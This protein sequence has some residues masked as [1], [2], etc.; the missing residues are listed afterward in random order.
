MN[1]KTNRLERLFFAHP[2]S[3]Q[4]YKDHPEVVLLDC[5]YKTNRFRMPLLNICAVTGNRKTVQVALCFLSGEKEADYDWAMSHFQDM[6]EEHGILEPDTWV[7]DRELALMNTL[8]DLFPDIDHILCTWHVNMNILANCRKHYP[9]DKQ[10]LAKKTAVNPQGYIPDPQWVK[11]LKDWQALLDSLTHAEYR[12]RLSQFCTH[13]KAAVDYIERVWLVWKE[14]L[15]R[16]WVDRCLHFG[17]RVTSPIEGCHAV[18]KAYLRVSTGDLKGVFDRL[19]LYW[20]TQHRDILDSRAQEQN[21]VVHHLNRRY[22][23]L[24]QGLVHDKALHLIIKEKAKLHKAE[25]EAT[26]LTEPCQCTVRSCMGVPCFHELSQRLSDAGQVL[27]E[28]IHPFWWYDRSKL[29][30]ILD[31]RP[32]QAVVLE[33]AIVKGKGRPRG[34]KGLQKKGAGP[35]GTRRDPSLFEFTSTAPAVLTGAPPVGLAER[36]AVTG[37]LASTSTTQLGLQ[38][39]TGQEDNYIPGTVP[40]RLYKRVQKA[41]EAE[42]SA[43]ILTPDVFA[44]TEEEEA[45][46]QAETDD[47]AL[48]QAIE[49]IRTTH[50]SSGRLRVDTKKAAENKA[51]GI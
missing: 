26:L 38:R 13:K 40:E 14:K 11:F 20:P 51:L 31:N 27:P 23:D 46:V 16:H 22:F 21:R 33:P 7:T 1:P 50:R 30:T 6:I 3:I 47:Q 45:I 8:D 29:R 15:V 32:A 34:S 35:D 41:H 48:S 4:I 19:L 10:D 18:L 39:T 28:D 49:H 44:P 24:I 5:T 2:D 36:P 37:F 25:T 42:D 12:T 43:F 9:A 17:I